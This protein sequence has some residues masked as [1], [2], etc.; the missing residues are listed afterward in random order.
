MY[1]ATN[2]CEDNRVSMN[3]LTICK[4]K[5]SPIYHKKIQ[6]FYDYLSL[7]LR[8]Y[9]YQDF[10]ADLHDVNRYCW[11]L[12]PKTK[13]LCTIHAELKIP[14]FLQTNKLV[15]TYNNMID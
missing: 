6:K 12:L 5:G 1:Q 7:T 10:S 3:T 14:F 11:P 2:F 9:C 8:R 13:K 15:I 4:E